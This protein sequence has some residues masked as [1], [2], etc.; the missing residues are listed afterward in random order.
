MDAYTIGNVCLDLIGMGLTPTDIAL[1]IKRSRRTV[2]RYLALAKS[3][4]RSRLPEGLPKDWAIEHLDN[5]CCDHALIP[6]PHGAAV[7][8]ERC[9]KCGYDGHHLLT[10]RRKAKPE[11]SK[12]KF[13]PKQ[14]R[15][16]LS[17]TRC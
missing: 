11:R 5:S 9:S 1:E 6:I 4:P 7:Y 13:K 2:F 8:C 12:A 14:R 17:E 3:D 10:I 15:K 16:S